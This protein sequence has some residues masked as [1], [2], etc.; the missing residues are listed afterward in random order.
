MSL[1]VVECALDHGRVAAVVAS[2]V[3]GP[4]RPDAILAYNDDYG[5]LLALRALLDAG[6]RVPEA[7]R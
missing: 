3:I 7:S 4:T 6:I 5:P 1:T 2:A